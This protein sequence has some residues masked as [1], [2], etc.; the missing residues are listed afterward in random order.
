MGILMCDG[1]FSS[2]ESVEMFS[3]NLVIFLAKPNKS[4]KYSKI[5]FFE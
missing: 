5:L 3:H 4:F 2:R 1:A